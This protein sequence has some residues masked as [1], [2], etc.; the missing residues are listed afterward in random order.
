MVGWWMAGVEGWLG[1]GR[2]FEFQRGTNYGAKGA[3]LTGSRVPLA[4]QT[5][6]QWAAEIGHAAVVGA[7]LTAEVDKEAKDEVR[8]RGVAGRVGGGSVWYGL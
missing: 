4:G 5:P 1:K 7:L 8:G 3:W 2:R 6:L